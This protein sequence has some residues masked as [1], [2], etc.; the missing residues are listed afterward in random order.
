M[1]RTLNHPYREWHHS[2]DVLWRSH[3]SRV[4]LGLVFELDR[5]GLKYIE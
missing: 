4:D 5:D 3:E 1:N 2:C